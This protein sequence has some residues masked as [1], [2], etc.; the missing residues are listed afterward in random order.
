MSKMESLE[1]AILR[2]TLLYSVLLL[3]GNSTLGQCS[4]D[5]NG[6][7][8][9]TQYGQHIFYQIR[10]G[11]QQKGCRK[12]DLSNDRVVEGTQYMADQ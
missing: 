1:E 11:Y 7:Q 12:S 8:H 10:N 6:N 3:D 4:A 9:G 5:D 2:M